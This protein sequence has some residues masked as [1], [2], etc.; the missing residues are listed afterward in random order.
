MYVVQRVRKYSPSL[1]FH[2]PD[3]GKKIHFRGFPMPINLG[4]W[5]KAPM[6]QIFHYLRFETW[7]RADTT[8][9]YIICI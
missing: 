8:L 1:K 3:V 5:G 4:A 7:F 2:F 6:K 9:V